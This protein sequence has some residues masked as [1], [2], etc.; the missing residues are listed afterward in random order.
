M[1]ERRLECFCSQYRIEES[2]EIRE[3]GTENIQRIHTPTHTCNIQLYTSSS[4]G[5]KVDD[6]GKT[7]I[8]RKWK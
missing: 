1:C 2:E 4:L 8:Y 7:G 5:W 6:A 3:D